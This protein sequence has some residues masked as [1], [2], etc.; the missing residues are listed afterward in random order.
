MVTKSIY[1]MVL[2]AGKSFFTTELLP[3][4]MA[5]MEPFSNPEK[6]DI[7][8]VMCGT[9]HGDDFEAELFRKGLRHAYKQKAFGMDEETGKPQCPFAAANMQIL[10]LHP[11]R[12][13]DGIIKIL[14]NLKPGAL[15]AF[16]LADLEA[17]EHDNPLP[18]D[19]SM[20]VP[21]KNQPVPAV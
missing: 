2:N 15:P 13:A 10:A 18:V 7:T 1:K 19:I 9:D 11:V 4:M 5:G 21:Q 14:P 3:Q 12:Q 8:D 6:I 17:L 16:I 20:I